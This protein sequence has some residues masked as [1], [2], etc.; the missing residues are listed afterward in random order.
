M[1]KRGDKSC[2]RCVI[3][4][5][6]VLDILWFICRRLVTHFTHIFQFPFHTT[7]TSCRRAL[8]HAID[9][10]TNTA[11]NILKILTLVYFFYHVFAPNLLV[12]QQSV[13]QYIGC[14]YITMDP[15]NLHHK[16]AEHH[17]TLHPKQ[18]T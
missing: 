17:I 13:H 7:K 10:A 9:V 4:W 6:K 16:A 18:S 5:I 1:R 12:R 11:P 8:K 14:C 2:K 15:E 3:V